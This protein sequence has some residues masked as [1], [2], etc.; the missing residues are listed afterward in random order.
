MARNKRG[1]LPDSFRLPAGKH[2]RA[3]DMFPR[4]RPGLRERCQRVTMNI[5]EPTNGRSPRTFFPV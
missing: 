1:V 5:R 2:S 4:G 3:G